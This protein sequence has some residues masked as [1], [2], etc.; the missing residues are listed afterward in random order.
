MIDRR[1]VITGLGCITS[2]AESHEELFEALCQSKS[3]V[4]YIE[5]FDTAEYPVKIGGEAKAFDVGRYLNAREAKRM[6]RFTQMATASAVQ[7]VKDSGL[8]FEKEDT[9]RAGVIVGTGIGG[10]K[11]IEDQH[12]R[13]LNKGPRKVSPFCVPKLM[14]NAACGCI[15][16]EYGL[17]GPNLCVVTACASASHAI[18]E[19]FWNVLTG[20]SDICITGGSE[21]ALTPVGLASFCSLKALSTRNEEPQLAS[22]PFD[23]DRNGF[24]LAEGA[25][26]LILEEYEHAK[27]RGAKIY[28]EMVGYG[29]TGDGHHITAP[30][31][32]GSGAAKAMEIALRQAKLNPEKIDYI[33]AHGTST[34]LNDAG[35]SKAIR[36]VF[37]S[38]A[39][40]IPVSSSKSCLG[41]SLGASGAVELIACAKTIEKGRIHPTANLQAVSE[42]CDPKMDF[43][44]NQPRDVDVQYALSNS[45]GFGGHNCTLI[46]GKV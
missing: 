11:E 45:L 8:D 4:S 1:V 25:G 7:A 28:A 35:E 21:A 10:I 30:L 43:V 12:V 46:I 38:G 33:N 39:Y 14:G 24:I 40:N 23:K 9:H 3:G 26:I 17:K 15:S 18:G 19:A 29:A 36:S 16:I 41:H 32:D 20:R 37:G 22:R 44:P 6:D 27:K 31:E 2:I 42:D 34:Q 5:S 13:L